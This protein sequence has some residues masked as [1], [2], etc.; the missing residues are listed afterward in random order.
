[1]LHCSTHIIARI[2]R[3]RPFCFLGDARALVNQAPS[4]LGPSGFDRSLAPLGYRITVLR[5][6]RFPNRSRP[7]ETSVGSMSMSLRE[8]YRYV[9]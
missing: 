6:V 1:M 2:F 8:M 4:G 5:P 9:L 7:T 3:A